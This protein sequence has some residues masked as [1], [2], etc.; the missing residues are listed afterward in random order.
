MTSRLQA[1]DG[2]TGMWGASGRPAVLLFHGLGAD[3][4]CTWQT[5]WDF[6]VSWDYNNPPADKDYGVQGSPPHRPVAE[7]GVSDMI[8]PA[9]INAKS[10]FRAL[11]GV[12][13]LSGEKFTV[14]MF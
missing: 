6:E 3:S 1:I 11:T 14:G 2:R 7:F 5:P 8:P 4:K 12:S 10:W 9:T 13:G